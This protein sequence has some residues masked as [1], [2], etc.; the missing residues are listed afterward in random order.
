MELEI[1]Q[2]VLD[3]LPL[4]RTIVAANTTQVHKKS[5][6]YFERLRMA[7]ALLKLAEVV[8]LSR[9]EQ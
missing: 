6:I 4:A 3:E 2:E 1:P 7:K 8:Y 9:R 5:P